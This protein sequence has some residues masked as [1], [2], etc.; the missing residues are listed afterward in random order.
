MPQNK[1]TNPL[2][3]LLDELP[4]YIES[5]P[6]AQLL[7]DHEANK[8][9]YTLMIKIRDAERRIR[10]YQRQPTRY[11]QKN[12]PRWEAKLALLKQQEADLERS[13][14]TPVSVDG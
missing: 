1:P 12:L 8:A 7:A 4:N 10:I 11:D 6:F 14:D 3:W 9:R 2:K 5:G 13:T